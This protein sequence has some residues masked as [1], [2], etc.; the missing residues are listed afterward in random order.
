[1]SAE[2]FEPFDQLF[3]YA[4]PSGSSPKTPEKGQACF[5][6]RRPGDTSFLSVWRF[7]C[8]AAAAAWRRP[9]QAAKGAPPRLRTSKTQRASR[10]GNQGALA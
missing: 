10:S 4:R 2:S 8:R 1:M 3:V 5:S 7:S 9:R 6:T